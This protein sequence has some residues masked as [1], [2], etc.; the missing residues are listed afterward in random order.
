MISGS[1][2]SYI[3]S[4]LLTLTLI[5]LTHIPFSYSM[6]PHSTLWSLGALPGAEAGPSSDLTLFLLGL[7]GVRP[8]LGVETPPWADTPLGVGPPGAYL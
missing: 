4:Q 7:L 3:F 2:N 1:F 8:P 5:P 6:A